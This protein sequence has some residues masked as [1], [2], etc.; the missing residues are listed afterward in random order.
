M[1]QQP[2]TQRLP[3]FIIIGR[4]RDGELDCISAINGAPIADPQIW[5]TLLVETHRCLSIALGEDLTVWSVHDINAVLLPD[6]NTI[7]FAAR[8][9]LAS[10]A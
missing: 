3:N 2:R 9:D 6:A 7:G 10:V 8:I 4:I 1:P 5:N